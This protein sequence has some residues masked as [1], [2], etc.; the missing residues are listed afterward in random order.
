M[1]LLG[2]NFL[3]KFFAII[4]EKISVIIKSVTNMIAIE[5]K[6]QVSICKDLFSW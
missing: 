6:N 3:T 4:V 1:I 5:M 2:N